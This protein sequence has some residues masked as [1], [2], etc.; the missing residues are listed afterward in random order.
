MLQ[1]RIAELITPERIVPM[2]KASG[3][4][5]VLQVLTRLAGREAGLNEEALL[6]C[7]LQMER[8]TAFGVGRG[9]AVPHALM[10][11]ISESVGAFAR[12]KHP[13]DFRAADERLVDLVFLLLAPKA[14]ADM[15]LPVL[16]R[17]VRRLRDREVLKHLRTGSS[18]EAAY[19]VLAT[20]SWRSQHQATASRPKQL[21]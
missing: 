20:D 11:G 6:H 16:S 9:V 17:I 15:L 10:N 2:L 1:V 19:A 14:D 3:K 7:I 8:R 18:A 5:G 13:V 21:A 12:L 4:A